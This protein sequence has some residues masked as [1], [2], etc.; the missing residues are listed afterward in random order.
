MGHHAD[1]LLPDS[2][3]GRGEVLGEVSSQ[4][5][6]EDVPQELTSH[7][8]VLGVHVQLLA[9]QL[10]Q[11]GVGAL[12][13]VQVLHGFPKGAQHFFAMSTD[14]GVTNDGGG[15]GEVPEVI[16]EP[17][18]PGVDNQ[19]PAEGHKH[20]PLTPPPKTAVVSVS[21]VQ[22]SPSRDPLCMVHS[23]G[24]T[25]AVPKCCLLCSIHRLPKPGGYF[26]DRRQ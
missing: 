6:D 15:A 19:Q 5:N 1:Q 24:F 11:L 7:P 12:D 17:L 22:L 8:E 9:V 14:L 4:H 21:S 20:T 26:S 25:P 10:R 3:A 13:V 16:K 2:L 23:N 18:G